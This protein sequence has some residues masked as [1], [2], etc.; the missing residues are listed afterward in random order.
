MSTDTVSHAIES[1][2]QDLSIRRSPHTIQAYSTALRHFQAFLTELYEDP[3][4]MPV[5]AINPEMALSFVR[6]LQATNPVSHTTLDNY[7]TALT[8]F[9]RWLLLPGERGG[10]LWGRGRGQ[11]VTA[12]A[13]KDLALVLQHDLT[14]LVDPHGANAGDA[15]LVGSPILALQ[16]FGECAQRVA[17]VHRADEL[18]LV[19][20]QV[21]NRLLGIV[22]DTQ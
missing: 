10:D 20:A 4:E 18:H 3:N 1:F 8:R 7:L 9:H 19:V 21:G 13:D 15:R 12:P 17:G 6:W 22:L 5:T 16:Y 2:R 11:A 14:V